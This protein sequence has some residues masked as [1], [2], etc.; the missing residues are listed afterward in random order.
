LGRALDRRLPSLIGGAYFRKVQSAV[1]RF[2]LV[3]FVPA[4][5]HPNQLAVAFAIIGYFRARRVWAYF[6]IAVIAQAAW[7]A[8]YGSAAELISRQ[9]LVTGNNFQLYLAILFSVWFLYELF[10]THPRG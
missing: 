7:W 9:S 1:E 4:A 8:V 6:V 3:S 2:G 5:I 10:F